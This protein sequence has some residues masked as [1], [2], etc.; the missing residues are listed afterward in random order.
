[1]CRPTNGGTTPASPAELARLC[2]D[3]LQ[4]RCRGFES[5]CAHRSTRW[6]VLRMAIEFQPVGNAVGNESG[7]GI[8]GDSFNTP[9]MTPPDSG[10]APTEARDCSHRGI[11]LLPPGV[12]S[13]PRD[14]VCRRG[15]CRGHVGGRRRRRS[16][17]R[18]C[19]RFRP[20]T[21]RAFGAG[22]AM[23][24]RRSSSRSCRSARSRSTASSSARRRSLPSLIQLPRTCSRS[25]SFA[26]RRRRPRSSRVR[27]RVRRWC[28]RV[29]GPRRRRRRLRRRIPGQPRWPVVRRRRVLVLGRRAHGRRRSATADVGLG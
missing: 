8:V 4:G 21:G 22:V 1:M 16:S 26:A 29:G 23:V 5:L 18:R 25:S 27:L 9:S 7:P 11:G 20:G 15:S 13:V 6:Y 2:R 12:R 28:R 17:S 3:D 19:A 14:G 24:R 10:I